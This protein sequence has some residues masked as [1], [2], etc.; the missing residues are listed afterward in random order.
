MAVDS[1]RTLLYTLACCARNALHTHFWTRICQLT[2][3]YITFF[4]RPFITRAPP[5]YCRL[6]CLPLLSI[7]MAILCLGLVGRF[8]MRISMHYM[9]RMHGL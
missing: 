1:V 4:F 2:D 3:S 6:V 7:C 8:S 5:L 9:I